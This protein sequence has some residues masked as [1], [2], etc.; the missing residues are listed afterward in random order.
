[1]TYADQ[2]MTGINDA[3]E[4]EFWEVAEAMAKVLA[5]HI[6]D[7]GEYPSALPPAELQRL[8]EQQARAAAYGPS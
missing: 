7:T 6:R 5:R 1:M 4:L 3:L 8:M 2:L